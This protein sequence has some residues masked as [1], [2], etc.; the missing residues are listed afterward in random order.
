M[1]RKVRIEPE[2][3]AELEGAVHWYD[4]HRHGLGADFLAAVDNTVAHISRWPVAGAPVPGVA[5][6]IPARRAPVPRFPYTVVY[7]VLDDTISVLAVAHDKR[8][9]GYWRRDRPG[10]DTTP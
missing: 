1:T 3:A 10:P 7:L 9:P 6:D 5:D 8:R 4:R 2:A